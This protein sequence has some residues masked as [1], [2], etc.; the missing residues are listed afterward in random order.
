MIR[1]IDLGDQI[2]EGTKSFAWFDTVIDKFETFNGCETWETWEKFEEDFK[3][4]KFHYTSKPLE[5]YK[6]LFQWGKVK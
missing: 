5:R 4:E 1:F 3:A 2:L 6:R